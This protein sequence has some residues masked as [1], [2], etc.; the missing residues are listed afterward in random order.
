MVIK[1][2]GKRAQGRCTT[3]G[4]M[5]FNALELAVLS[6]ATAGRS[7]ASVALLREAINKGNAK[8]RRT[9][10]QQRGGMDAAIRDGS[11]HP[12]PAGR[13]YSAGAGAPNTAVTQADQLVVW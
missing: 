11:A 9:S 7:H 5:L 8:V 6:K 4:N 13:L 3:D 1:L 12:L 10:Q 2:A